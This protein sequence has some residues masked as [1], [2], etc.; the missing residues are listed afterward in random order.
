MKTLGYMIGWL[1]FLAV[2]PGAAPAE[3]VT[4]ATYNVEN[5]RS[6]EP[7]TEAG[8][9][10]EYPKPEAEKQALRA[11][12]KGIN[13]DVLVLPRNGCSD[14]SGRTAAGLEGGGARLSPRGAARGRRRGPACGPA[15]E[16]APLA[17]TQRGDLEVK[18]F[19][20]KE[21]V[22]RGLLEV[23]FKV[24]ERIDRL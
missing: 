9:G 2:V 4:L 19:R 3:T 22:K 23:R 5:Y 1:A 12:L 24:G 15:G 7:V 8:Y 11:G 13:A 10:K 6:G 14:V 20:Q 17:T 16:A 21:R 18:Y